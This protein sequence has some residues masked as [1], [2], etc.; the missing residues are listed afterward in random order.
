[1]PQTSVLGVEIIRAIT[2]AAR[3]STD[4]AKSQ[5]EYQRNAVFQVAMS[6]TATSTNTSINSNS[7]TAPKSDYI[8]SMRAAGYNEDLDQYIAMK[9]QGITPE[10]A[11]QM[12]NIGF[13]KPSAHELLALKIHGVTPEYLNELKAGGI[14]PENF[15]D[16]IS[17]RIFKVTPEFIAGMK[18]AG[19]S[20]LSA[21]KLVELRVQ[22]VT[23]DFA[24]TAKQQFPDISAN[25]LVQLRIF[26]ID[27]AFI[28]KAKELGLKPITVRKLVQLRNS[29]LL[30]DQR[31]RE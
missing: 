13:G 20:D 6:Q 2:K 30:D 5:A 28:A 21:K 14:K 25:E 29:G 31:V 3:D 4:Y 16:V 1:M 7:N 15:Q 27:D 19:F 12:A 18:S 17:Y 11:S 22:N 26:R 10:Y 8:T 24:R 23:P 9:V